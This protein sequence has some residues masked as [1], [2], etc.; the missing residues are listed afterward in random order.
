[1]R[2]KNKEETRLFLQAVY[3]IVTARKPWRMLHEKYRKWNS[4]FKGFRKCSVL[5]IF[6]D[7]QQNM[8]AI[9]KKIILIIDF[10][11]LS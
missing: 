2:V 7:F 8:L 1:M 6:Q 3:E 9:K 4:I 11:W 10:H 5:V